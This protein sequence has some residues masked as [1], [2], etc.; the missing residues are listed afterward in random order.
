MLCASPHR[1]R[2]AQGQMLP[3]VSSKGLQHMCLFELNAD[4]LA[5]PNRFIAWCG[6]SAVCSNT[7]FE[8]KFADLATHRTQHKAVVGLGWHTPAV[9]GMACTKRQDRLQLTSKLGARVWFA[10]TCAQLG[11]CCLCLG[12]CSMP[13]CGCSHSQHNTLTSVL[14]STP[15][16][17]TTVLRRGF[18]SIADGLSDRVA[19]CSM[20][21]FGSKAAR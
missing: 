2:M 13:R 17:C 8:V 11:M 1:A 3:V 18:I 5:P 4:E 9:G 15:I 7:R 10:T 12:W 21:V 16:P 19:V 14:Q 20:G 6:T